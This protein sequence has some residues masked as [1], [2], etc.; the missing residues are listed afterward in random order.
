MYNMLQEFKI[1]LRRLFVVVLKVDHNFKLSSSVSNTPFVAENE[2]L[3]KN[4]T[5]SLVQYKNLLF[6]VTCIELYC[7]CSR[8]L[9]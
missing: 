1:Y 7:K 4:Q 5:F 8:T 6:H 9:F 3:Y 2:R